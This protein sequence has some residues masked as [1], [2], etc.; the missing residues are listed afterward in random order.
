MTLKPTDMMEIQSAIDD[1][2]RKYPRRPKPTAEVALAW[3][4]GK[5]ISV[6]TSARVNKRRVAPGIPEKYDQAVQSQECGRLV[7]AWEQLRLQWNL[8]QADDV[9]PWTTSVLR[10]GWW[11]MVAVATASVFC[12]GAIIGGLK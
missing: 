6:K 5:R 3:R 10:L 9:Q 11:S 8:S 2:E 4:M 7:W 12:F 1:Y